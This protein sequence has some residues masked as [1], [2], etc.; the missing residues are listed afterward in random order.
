MHGRRSRAQRRIRNAAG[1]Q[2][3]GLNLKSMALLP[4]AKGKKRG[5]VKGKSGNPAGK[6]PGTKDRRTLARETVQ[7]FKGITPL[8]FMLAT[9]QAPKDQSSKADRMWAA[10]KAAPYVHRKMP[11]AIEGT[12]KPIPVT[13]FDVAKLAAMDTATLRKA[14]EVLK[15]MGIIAKD[16]DD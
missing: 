3:I 10:D 8:E 9:L 12:D 4:N 15:D 7:R 1:L 6:K 13:V 2:F 5:F 11:I 14:E 16:E